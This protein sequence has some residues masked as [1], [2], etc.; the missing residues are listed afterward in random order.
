VRMGELLT[1]FPVALLEY[2]SGP[3]ERK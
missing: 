3:P 2:D 1:V